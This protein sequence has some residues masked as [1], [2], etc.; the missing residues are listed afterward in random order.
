MYVYVLI[1]CISSQ[2]HSVLKI[3]IIIFLET[4]KQKIKLLSFKSIENIIDF[5]L[6][7]YKNYV[8][9]KSVLNDFSD[10]TSWLI[11]YYVT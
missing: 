3:Y 5:H 9:S 8:F 11:P 2:I 6:I 4:V 1:D 7:K 10:L